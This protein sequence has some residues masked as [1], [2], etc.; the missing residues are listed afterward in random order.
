VLIINNRHK[1]ENVL[2]ASDIISPHF[3]HDR[4]K[5]DVQWSKILINGLTI[6]D[7]NDENTGIKDLQTEF[8]QHA[9]IQLAAK[10]R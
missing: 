7:W 5:I 4:M 6:A 10:F 1:I 3:K 2:N 8:M 9:G